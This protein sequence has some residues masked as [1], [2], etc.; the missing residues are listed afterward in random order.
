[1]KGSLQDVHTVVTAAGDSRSLFLPAG[2]GRPKSLIMWDGR[3]VLARAIDSYALNPALTSVAIHDG[4]DREWDLGNHISQIF[5]CIRIHSIPDGVAG[6]LASALIGLEHVDWESPLVV[7][8]GD[9]MINGGVGDFVRWAIQSDQ[10]AATIAFPSINPRWS[11]L[12]VD[13]GGAVRQVAE[14]QVIGPLATTGVFYFQSA[15]LFV[16]AATWCLVNNASHNGI[17]F[18]STTLNYLISRA[19]TV[20]YHTISRSEYRS[21]SLP[22]DFT[23]QS[24]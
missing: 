4:E 20:G 10:D 15:R 21:W 7:A 9:S 11:Y 13:S 19:L 18:V 24:G 2:F 22:I 14:K 6:A 12:A 5:P 8:A 23:Q 1:M 3:E 17:F 16:D